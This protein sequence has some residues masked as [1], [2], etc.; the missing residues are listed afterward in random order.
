MT[1]TNKKITEINVVHK[2]QYLIASESLLSSIA[3]D[4]TSL[5]LIAIMLFLNYKYFGNHT[6]IAFMFVLL[7]FLW[8]AVKGSNDVKKFNS[9]EEAIKWLQSK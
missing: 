1:E 3:K 5:G 8:I 9:K 2:K 7:I 4:I 6:I